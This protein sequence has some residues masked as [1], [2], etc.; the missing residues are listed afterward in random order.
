VPAEAATA[1]G[2]IAIIMDGNGRWAEARGLPRAAGHREGVRT[3]RALV[4]HCVRT[5]LPALT[6]FA[7]SSENWKR[8]G[9]EV[10]LLLDLFIAALAEHVDA[11]HA[12]GVSV[13]FIGD[14][15]GFPDDLCEAI[16][17]AESKTAGNEA[18]RLAVA[19]NYGGRWDLARACRDIAARAAA[20]DI[21]PARVD[22]ALMARSMSLAGMPDPDLFI[23]T[24]GERR[25]SNFL[26]WEL[27][28]TELYFTDEL[29]PDFGPSS[30]DAAIH[31]YT[32]RERRFGR[33]P[34]QIGR[35]EGG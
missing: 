10:A 17:R 21:V 2:H 5:G 35:A 14:R 6:V 33:T 26:L 30:L 29:W 11:L 13:R 4:E 23:R 27:A 22:E 9:R 24:G 3:L 8:P 25:I 18:L 1:P 28:Y 31:W 20:G 12:N 32:Q 34:G 16:R 7:F 19:A 15:A